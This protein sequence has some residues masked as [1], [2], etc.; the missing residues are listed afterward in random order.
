VY[1]S[2]AP[3]SLAA[4]VGVEAGV[5]DGEEQLFR[6]QFFDSARI[7]AVSPARPGAGSTSLFEVGVC[8]TFRDGTR[9]CERL[10]IGEIWRFGLE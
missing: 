7:S 6:S 9:L 10:Q 1:H 3:P 4:V 8:G 5:D 2:G